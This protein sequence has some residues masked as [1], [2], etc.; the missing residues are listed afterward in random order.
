VVGERWTL[1]IVQEL[2]K[3]G[4]RYGELSK[5][6]PGIGTSVLSDRLRK[7]ESAGIVERRAGGVGQGVHYQLS[8]RGRALEPALRALREWGAE[9]LFDPV[10]D[11][12]AEQSFDLRYVD[13]AE[14]I[15]DGAF[16]MTVEQEPITFEFSDARLTQRPGATAAPE[17]SIATDMA[18]LRRWARGELDWDEGLDSGDVRLRG[19]RRAWGHWLAASGYALQYP[20]APEAPG[21]G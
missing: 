16:Q 9:F 8:E 6:L 19:P 13:G 7:L 2:Q 11:G 18:F 4:M 20:P 12:A 14:L 17:L 1:V 15:P 10:A 5:R 21:G 3:R